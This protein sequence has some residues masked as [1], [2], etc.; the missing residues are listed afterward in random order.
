MDRW[1][2]GYHRSIHTPRS[3]LT[4]SFCCSLTVFS[5]VT[6]SI[7]LKSGQTA[8]SPPV[9]D[10]TTCIHCVHIHCLST[11]QCILYVWEVMFI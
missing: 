5:P 8:S 10:M 1:C 11:A 3:E 7:S 4:L 2:E 6:G 9:P